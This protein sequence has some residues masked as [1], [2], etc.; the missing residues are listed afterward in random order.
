MKIYVIET[1]SD[2]TVQCGVSLSKD[3][4]KRKVDELNKRIKN[5]NC[6]HKYWIT[7]YEIN[8]NQYTEFDC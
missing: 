4:A 6:Y 3:I 5:S 1:V 7:E 8:N 2:Y